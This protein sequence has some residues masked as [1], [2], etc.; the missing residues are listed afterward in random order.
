MITGKP[1]FLDRLA[2]YLVLA[3]GL[4]SFANAGFM[5]I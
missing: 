3:V 4:F 5:I 1:D 2:Q